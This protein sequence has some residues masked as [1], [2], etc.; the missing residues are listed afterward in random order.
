MVLSGGIR[1]GNT[2]SGEDCKAKEKYA[3]AQQDVPEGSSYP[4]LPQGAVLENKP[5]KASSQLLLLQGAVLENTP[6]FISYNRTYLPLWDVISLL[7]KQLEAICKQYAIPLAIV[8]GKSLADLAHGVIAA[9]LQPQMQD[10]LVCVQNFRDLAHPTCIFSYQCVLAL[11]CDCFDVQKL[12]QLHDHV[13]HVHH[14]NCALPS[15]IFLYTCE[16]IHELLQAHGV[17]IMNIQEVAQQ[18]RQ[19]GR[20]F[21]GDGGQGLA[22]TA[23]QMFVCLELKAIATQGCTRLGAGRASRATCVGI[24]LTIQMQLACLRLF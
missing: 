13:T 7:I 21:K 1:I 2:V 12:V 11:H 9:G 23:I 6:E 22:A 18:L 10:L 4:V 15:D 24:C 5:M 17:L 16:K 14:V 8:D 20:R 3:L 19:P